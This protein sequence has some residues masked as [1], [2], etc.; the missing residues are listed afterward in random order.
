M[1]G[2][3]LTIAVIGIVFWLVPLIQQ[4]AYTK[5]T[6][7]IGTS[8]PYNQQEGNAYPEYT[9][10]YGGM[11]ADSPNSLAVWAGNNNAFGKGVTVIEGAT[12]TVFAIEI[13]ISEV[14]PDY[15][16]ILVKHLT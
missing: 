9:F 10:R 7:P 13:K 12:Y 3:I 14:H 1:I 2:V 15:I 11:L 5:L 16:V 4:S 8:V 6:L